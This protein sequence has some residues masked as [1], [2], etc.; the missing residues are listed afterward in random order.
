MTTQITHVKVPPPRQL[1]SSETLQSLEQWY[2]TFK[3]YY[4][5]D[6]HF[7]VFTLPTTT[8]NPAD[9]VFGFQAESTGLKRQPLELK[10]D[11]I[12][13]L[14]AL[15]SYMP[16]GYLVEKF[17]SSV[18]SLGNAFALICEHYGVSPSQES[19]LDFVSIHKDANESYR[20]YHERLLAFARQHL[21]KA[22]TSVD[23]VNSGVSGDK[24]TI[25]HMNLITLIWLKNINPALVNIV[26]TEYSLELR[27]N[28]QLSELV[29]RIS[30]NIDNLL[31]RYDQGS[32]VQN[33]NAQEFVQQP[34]VSK[35]QKKN[36]NQFRYRQKKTKQKFCHKCFYLGDKLGID[37]QHSHSPEDC[38]RQ[39]SVINMIQ[40]EENAFMDDDNEDDDSQIII[41]GN[42]FTQKVD[43]NDVSKV[44]RTNCSRVY[45]IN[46][47][48]INPILSHVYQI[49][50]SL[51]KEKSPTILLE[52]AGKEVVVTIDEGAE[53]SC[54][55][56]EVAKQL[57]LPITKTS[58]A[59]VAANKSPMRAIGETANNLY[60]VVKQSKLSSIINLG[61]VLI[62]ANLG[63]TYLL[64]NQQK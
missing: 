26:R 29:P 37:I 42:T 27:Q 62:I 43:S 38:P 47:A 34:T 23:G 9:D 2:R 45:S 64:A 58:C 54:V 36:S 16:Y 31:A 55:N 63:L 17:V 13:F 19:F 51:R 7:K 22:N 15:S 48:N 18:S 8:W 21:T 49:V 20:Q 50:S 3:Q 4:K 32:A 59:R 57:K 25:S 53:V 28:T 40:S 12:H 44:T 24:L 1:N 10:E 52:I 41:E 30:V 35:I 14:H 56:L 5:R 39:Q 33:I 11:C 46:E 60:A 61:N 6:S